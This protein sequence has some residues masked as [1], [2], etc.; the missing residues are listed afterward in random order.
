MID[1]VTVKELLKACQQEVAKGNGDKFIFISRDDE[2]N[3]WHQLW[4]N[5]TE[6]TPDTCDD[7]RVWGMGSLDP[8]RHILLG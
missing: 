1:G 3:G 8:D 5:F 6:L 4:Y 7:Y 2:G